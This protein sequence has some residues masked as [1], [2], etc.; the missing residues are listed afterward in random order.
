[1]AAKIFVPH[2]FSSDLVRT[3]E[4]LFASVPEKDGDVIHVINTGKGYELYLDERLRILDLTCRSG[5]F[6]SHSG[7][8][9]PKNLTDITGFSAPF[10]AIERRIEEG[11][12][13]IYI[14]T[15]KGKNKDVLRRSR[16]YQ[17]LLEELA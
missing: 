11:E 15:R 8:A 2:D 12:G 1:M 16:E 5:P 3:I 14:L 6:K 4:S 9:L 13:A 17:A 7:Y 10:F